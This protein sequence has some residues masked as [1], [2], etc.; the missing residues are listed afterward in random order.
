MTGRDR[1]NEIREQEGEGGGGGHSW[2]GG[3]CPYPRDILSVMFC[4]LPGVGAVY[5]NL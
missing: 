2:C 5:K 3:G 1:G 4:P